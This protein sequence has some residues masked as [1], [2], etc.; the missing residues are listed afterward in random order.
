MRL[1]NYHKTPLFFWG[2]GVGRSCSSLYHCLSSCDVSFPSEKSRASTNPP[3]CPVLFNLW[4]PGFP[5]CPGF[6][7]VFF[8]LF[9]FWF[10]LQESRGQ[11]VVSGCSRF[12]HLKF[13]YADDH[14]TGAR[15]FVAL[16]VGRYRHWKW[17]KRKC[18]WH[19]RFFYFYL[20]LFFHTFF[21]KKQLQKGGV[22]FSNFLLTHYLLFFAL[23][24]WEYK[25]RQQNPKVLFFLAIPLL[26]IFFS[27]RRNRSGTI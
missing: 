7:F 6:L 11:P 23:S 5:F 22:C 10:H 27:K 21:S 25:Y 18:V 16:V 12:P 24:T 4:S 20:F 2:G 1:Y 15:I 19:M 3:S 14:M 9:F 17:T 8:F 26:F 13:V